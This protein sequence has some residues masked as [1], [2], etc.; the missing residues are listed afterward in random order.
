MA[1]REGIL[2]S[3]RM[4]SSFQTAFPRE[5]L[6]EVRLKV[7]SSLSTLPLVLRRSLGEGRSVQ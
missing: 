5:T 4:C 2:I 6:E 1:Q 7:A 3:D